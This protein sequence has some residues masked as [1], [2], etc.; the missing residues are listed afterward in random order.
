MNSRRVRSVPAEE[1]GALAAP[2]AGGPAECAAGCTGCGGSRGAGCGGAGCGGCA[3]ACAAGV[4]P[5][6]TEGP[7]VL[8]GASE[9]SVGGSLLGEE[10]VVLGADGAALGEGRGV[11]DDSGAA[12][13]GDGTSSSAPERVSRARQRTRRTAARDRIPPSYRLARVTLQ[14]NAPP[15]GL[16]LAEG[17]ISLKRMSSRLPKRTH[18]QRRR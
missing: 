11:L 6:L 13:A 7:I 16:Q 9:S 18:S 4:S 5:P 12:G 17:A 10:G 8:A 1:A 15:G 14:R 2:L 3:E